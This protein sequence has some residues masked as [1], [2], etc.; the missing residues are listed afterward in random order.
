MHS[1]KAICKSDEETDMLVGLGLMLLLVVFMI[2][3][4]RYI[5]TK[6]ACADIAYNIQRL[7]VMLSHLKFKSHLFF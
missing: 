3:K 1:G 6:H 4:R 5:L 7:H 2:D